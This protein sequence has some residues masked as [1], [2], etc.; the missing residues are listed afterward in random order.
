MAACKITKTPD[1][2][3]TMLGLQP[4]VTAQLNGLDAQFVLDSGAFYSLMSSAAAA[5]FKLPLQPAPFGFRIKGVGGLAEVKLT[6]VKA[7]TFAGMHLRDIEFM[8]GGSEAGQ[9]SAG[10]LGQNFLENFDVEYDLG[11]G[12]F[13]L[14]AA[15]DCKHSMM[16]YWA[17]AGSVS[18]MDISRTTPVEPH[19]VGTAYIN[20]KKIRVLFDTGAAT[21]MISLKAA[22]RA[23]ITPTTP[24]VV[25]GG[26]ES[27]VGRQMVKTYIAPF[28][29]FKIGDNEEIKNARLRIGDVDLPEGDMLIGADF[30]LSHHL[31][32]ANS[33]HRLF[34]TYNGGPVFNLAASREQ[35]AAADGAD[36]ANDATAVGKPDGA[37]LFRQGAAL[38][39]RGDFAQAIED[40]T[41][42]IEI[43]A[44]EPEYFYQRGMTS[45]RNRQIEPA[46][47]D[48]DQALKLDPNYLPALMARAELRMA[49][50]DLSGATSDLDSADRIA[51]K[52]ADVRYSMAHL[53]NEAGSR[54]AALSQYDLWIAN[55]P[56][57]AKMAA[58]LNGRCWTRVLDGSDLAKAL[59]DCN[60][61]LRRT[62]KGDQT[63]AFAL[64]GRGLA[65]LRLG[66]FDK[67]IADFDASLKLHP[68]NA[69]A[70]YGRGV[71]KT[72]LNRPGE[73]ESD[74]AAAI[75][76][77]AP[78]ADNF[79]RDGIRQ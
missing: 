60:S 42:A 55:H 37:A 40:F 2:P 26:L 20:D 67:S 8:V 69:W 56:D 43:D 79:V 66:A 58:A 12:V 16:A 7:F 28:A 34:F 45:W 10:V 68:K 29:S 22:A 70:L 72:K 51:P 57:D 59:D 53:Y 49:K 27:G 48:L 50:R 35:S 30:F 47:A 75:A 9:G 3:I 17:D 46:A 15:E 5:Q 76:I 71:A 31:Y 62:L 6:R 13:R 74:K 4:M 18:A 65:Q 19:T 44:N 33:Q 38:S 1:V 52:Q 61:V 63:Y 41:K 54:A 32:V 25:Y 64:A 11:R 78:I 21:S 14:A 36:S 24:G 39:G 77:W 23:G 73:A